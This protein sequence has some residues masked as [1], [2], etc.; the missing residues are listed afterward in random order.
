MEQNGTFG[1]AFATTAL[2]KD[3]LKSMI[4]VGSLSGQLDQTLAKIVEIAT[5]QLEM[6][7]QIFNQ[8]FQ[9]LVVFLV[10]M[11]IVETLFICIF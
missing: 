5:D 10:G 3:D 8:F 11:S 7:L 6:T 4:D 1:E 2:L 9:R